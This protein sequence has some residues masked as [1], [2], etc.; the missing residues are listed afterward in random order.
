METGQCWG[1][2]SVIYNITSTSTICTTKLVYKEGVNLEVGKDKDL[3]AEYTTM[4]VSQLNVIVNVIFLT[5]LL[6]I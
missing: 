1:E 6:F 4:I 5:V 2:R 3:M